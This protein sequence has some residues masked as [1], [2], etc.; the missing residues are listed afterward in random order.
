MA[1]ES[2]WHDATPGVRAGLSVASSWRGA[3]ALTGLASPGLSVAMDSSWLDVSTPLGLAATP[4]EPVVAGAS[5]PSSS[6]L[7]RASTTLRAGTR[8]DTSA[9]DAAAAVPARAREGCSVDAQVPP[10]LNCKLAANCP[11]RAS[12][13]VSVS[14]ALSSPSLSSLFPLSVPSSD[15]SDESTMRRRRVVFLATCG[16]SV[17]D[18]DPDPDPDPVPDPVPVPVPTTSPRGVGGV[19]ASHTAPACSTW[20]SI[21]A[22][23]AA[24]ALGTATVS[25]ATPPASASTDASA[26]VPQPACSAALAST[27]AVSTPAASAP[28]PASTPASPT[29]AGSTAPASVSTHPPPA[30]PSPSSPSSPE[31][32][33]ATASFSSS[34]A[35]AAAIWSC[36]LAIFLLTCV[37]GW[38]R[39]ASWK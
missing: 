21:F 28:V 35:P 6:L 29:S 11:A 19:S 32:S 1:M 9:V 27:P 39:Y 30:A 34:L 15:S 4:G 12:A 36:S 24:A 26:A 23:A 16:A 31:L 2:S 14:P 37:L 7:K 25:T 17:S 22:P 3:C 18:S 20:A 8:T 13:A 33:T 5:S 10:P 38:M